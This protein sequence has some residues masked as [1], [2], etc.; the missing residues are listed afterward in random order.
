MFMWP[1]SIPPG[2]EYLLVALMPLSMFNP[3][4][5]P[6]LTMLQFGLIFILAC[7][8]FT[9]WL[10]FKRLKTSIAIS[11]VIYPITVFATNLFIFFA[12]DNY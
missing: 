9:A 10:K 7:V 6:L 3:G 8:T 12:M 4:R 2:L 1:D 5:F 11:M